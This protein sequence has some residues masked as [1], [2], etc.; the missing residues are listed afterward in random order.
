MNPIVQFGTSRFLQAHADLFVSEALAAGAGSG[1]AIGAITIVQTS[2]SAQS[3][4]RVAAFNRAD[5]F[6]VRLR[7]WQNGAAIDIE[8]RVDSVTE[9]L[10]TSLDWA[11]IVERVAGA[12]QVI[13]SN[14]SDQGYAL[15]DADH[16]GLLDGDVPPHSFPAKLLVLLH[17]RFLR[18]G[19]PITL[20]PCEL[21]TRNGDVLK[22]LV[23]TLARQW[24]LGTEFLAY[25][26]HRCIWI[27]SLVD[28]IVSE[29][30]EPIGAVAEPYA[31]WAIEAQPN[32]TLPCSHPQIVVTDNLE[33]YERLK[34]FLLNLGHSY[35]AEQWLQGAR[36][37][38]ATVA[39]AMSDAATSMQLDAL[40]E[41][42]VLPVFAAL[43]EQP[44]AREYLTQVRERFRNPFLAH[45][46]S[47]IAQNHAEKKQRR[48]APVVALAE[49][50]GLALP[51]QRLRAALAGSKR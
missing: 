23:L 10:Q 11:V 39:Q 47:D 16:A 20:F 41:E 17:A 50:L 12:A 44:A 32:M 43:G 25:L 38:D 5:G 36:A 2:D 29:P 35:L 37:A 33:R 4:R 18:T 19:A 30:I 14:T 3:A 22:G 28:R 51:Q 9:A 40:W 48:F 8:Q 49:Q 31:L 26:E 45:R 1:S 7:G 6:L 15:S 13:L 24:Q 27:N 42:E 34:L 46:L 21:V